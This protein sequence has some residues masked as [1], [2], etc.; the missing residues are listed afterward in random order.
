MCRKGS[1]RRLKKV[2]ADT[3]ALQKATKT[4]KSPAAAGLPTTAAESDAFVAGRLCVRRG[5]RLDVEALMMEGVREMDVIW[6]SAAEA[7]DAMRLQPGI[8]GWKA[9]SVVSPLCFIC[10][11]EQGLCNSQASVGLSVCPIW[12]LH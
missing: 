1:H 12:P 9:A 10:T 5:P 8:H 3:A 4:D 11:A 6:N 7:A 2:F